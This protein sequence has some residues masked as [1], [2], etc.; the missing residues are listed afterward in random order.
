MP[1]IFQEAAWL[2]VNMQGQEGLEEWELAAGVH[3]NSSLC[4]RMHGQF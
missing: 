1:R 3:E 4:G 2:F